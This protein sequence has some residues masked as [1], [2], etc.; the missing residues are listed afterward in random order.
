MCS[1][2]LAHKL[3]GPRGIG[4]LLLG[5]GVQVQACIGG[6]GQEGGLRAG[7]EAVPLAAGLVRAVALASE[8]LAA[9]GGSDPIGPL[10]D[11]LLERLLVL[12]GLELS[13]PDPRCPAPRA[14]M[15]LQRLPHHLSLLVSNSAAEPV[16]GRRL[17]QSLWQ[18]GFAASSG[19]ACSSGRQAPSPVLLAMGYTP[20]QASSSLRLSLGP[21]H[22]TSV[23]AQ[24]PAALER[25]R[26]CL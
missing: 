9:H 21:W 18:Q 4:A 13:G 11:Q 16:S 26:S 15:T 23:L 20:E 25:A 10:R 24:L 14:A 2:D 12:P 19:S 3:M 7:T 22:N 5:P 17:V 6:G 1:S 8:R